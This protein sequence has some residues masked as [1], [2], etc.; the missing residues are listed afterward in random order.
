MNTDAVVVISHARP[1]QCGAKTLRF[2]ADGGIPREAV[3]LFVA[4]EEQAAYREA[5]D[6]GLYGEL[7]RGGRSLAEQRNRSLVGA[8]PSGTKVVSVDDDV[9]ELRQR[10][11]DKATVRVTD[12]AAE[13]DRGW[14]TAHEQRARLW[15]IYPVLNPMFMRSRTSTGLY[16]VIGHLFGVVTTK[17]QWARTSFACKDDY[18]R[19][20][21]YFRHDEAVV[22]LDDLA[23]K[24]KLGAAGGIRARG[25]E[26]NRN[27]RE[28]AELLARFP[29][30]VAIQK[31][32]G[33]RGLEIR[34]R[35]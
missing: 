32:R 16:F 22:R 31:R 34:L 21:E 25:D 30:W 10:T 33:S 4:P 17:A 28:V 35:A 20:L 2:L 23:A 19:S 7:H 12:L 8:W 14:S 5:L 9:T 6:P 27:R 15:G 29:E 13:F 24:T 18:E 3:H 26:Q 1:E 11:S